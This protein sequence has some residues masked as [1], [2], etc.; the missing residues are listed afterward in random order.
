M[1]PVFDQGDWACDEAA[2]SDEAHENC[3]AWVIPDDTLLDDDAWEVKVQAFLQDVYARQNQE[4]E[5]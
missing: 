3:E 2:L 5:T 4:V 1:I